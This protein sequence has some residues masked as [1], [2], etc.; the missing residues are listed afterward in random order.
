MSSVSVAARRH[1]AR[2]IAIAV[3]LMAPLGLLLPRA[4]ADVSGARGLASP[5]APAVLAPLAGSVANAATTWATVAMGRRDGQFDLFWELFSLDAVTGRFALVT[6]PGVASNGGLIVGQPT[7]GTGALVGFGVSQDLGFS[8]LAFSADDGQSWS[9]GG[10]EQGLER[11]PSA[12]GVGQRGAAFALVGISAPQVVERSGTGLTDWKPEVSEAALAATPAGERCE[13]GSLEG[14][15]VAGDSSPILGVSCRAEGVAGLFVRAGATWRLAQ[16]RVPASLRSASFTTLRIAPFAALFAATGRTR[17]VVAA[18]HTPGGQ[19]WSLSPAL[20]LSN[21][22]SMV[23]T[24]TGPGGREFV[25]W[26]EGGS[27]HAEV[28]AGPGGRWQPLSTVP[29][30]TAT[31]ALGAD[32]QVDA[33]SVDDTHLTV[34]RLSADGDKWTKVQAMTVPIAFGS[35]S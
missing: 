31:I 12:I 23:A 35:S 21:S 6:P 34:W 8:P 1:R 28:I 10:F 33:L 11:T 29:E 4:G 15:A 25:L 20:G 32:G 3:S 2:G 18:W 9:P 13:V 24:G 7:T 5:R 16:V 26:S 19:A 27:E 22:A 17:S 30:E 14:V